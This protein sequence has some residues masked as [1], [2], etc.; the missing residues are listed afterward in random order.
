MF[1]KCFVTYYFACTDLFVVVLWTG[2]ISTL[3]QSFT[4]IAVRSS[5]LKS[6]SFEEPSADSS[7]TLR[8]IINHMVPTEIR[9]KEKER[10]PGL[11]E[12][13][14]MRARMNQRAQGLVRK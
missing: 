1:C 7:V 13:K 5:L 12:K 2:Y 6:K 3:G 9:K 4:N 10:K 14:R 11:E 8:K